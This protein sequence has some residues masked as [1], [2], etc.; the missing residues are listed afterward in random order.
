MQHVRGKTGYQSKLMLMNGKWK[1]STRDQANHSKCGKHDT[2]EFKLSWQHRVKAAEHKQWHWHHYVSQCITDVGCITINC[3]H[4]P[5]GILL[6]NSKK[7]WIPHL[8]VTST[9]H[10][11]GEILKCKLS[12]NLKLEGDAYRSHISTNTFNEHNQNPYWDILS[13]TCNQFFN[14]SRH[15]M[16]HGLAD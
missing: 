11:D 9:F 5:R 8:C 10:I 13:S 16:M 6:S 4:W 15:V 1:N 12:I 7:E 2:K 14:H 3:K